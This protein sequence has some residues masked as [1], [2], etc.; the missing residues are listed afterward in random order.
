SPVRVVS[1]PSAHCRSALR[2]PLTL[3]QL[4]RLEAEHDNLRAALDWSGDTAPADYARLA[5]A[6]WEFWDT[7]GHFT[8]GWARLERALMAHQARDDARFNVSIGAGVLAYRLDYT[9]RSDDILS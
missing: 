5:G 1:R 7:R 4:D 9:Q 3:E 8:E 2:G 6:L